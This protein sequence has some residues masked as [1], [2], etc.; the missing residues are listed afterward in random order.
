VKRGKSHEEVCEFF[1]IGIATLY[2]WL[3][4]EE[5]QGSVSPARRS[6]YKNSKISPD[7]L[8]KELDKAPDATLS[9]LAEKFDCCLQ[10]VDYWLRKLCI[11]RKKNN[12]LRGAGREKTQR[13]SSP[14]RE[15]RSS[16]SGLLG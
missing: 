1:G 4:L 16:E 5:T 10:N 14:D 8:L 13:I 7:K 2:R 12:T 9:E 6:A 11:T 3:R 15:C